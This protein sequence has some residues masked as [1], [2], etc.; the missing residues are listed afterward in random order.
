MGQARDLGKALHKGGRI[1]DKGIKGALIGCENI[2]KTMKNVRCL[3]KKLRTLSNINGDKVLA[4]LKE[5]EATYDLV[6]QIKQTIMLPIMH[7][8]IDG[9]VTSADES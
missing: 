9:I 6:A 8:A 5:I 2:A 4:I 1:H 3:I 7:F